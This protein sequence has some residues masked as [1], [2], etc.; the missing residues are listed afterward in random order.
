MTR[1]HRGSLL[2]RCRALPSPSP[3]RFIPALCTSKPAQ[4][5]TFAIGRLLYAVVVARPAVAAARQILDPAQQLLP[6]ELMGV[7]DAALA[8]WDGGAAAAAEERLASAL[9][10]AHELHFF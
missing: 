9:Q 8:A 5:R 2:L 3:C 10:L 4:L 7:L 1:G 6:D